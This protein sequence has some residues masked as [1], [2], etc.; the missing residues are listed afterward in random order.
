MRLAIF[1]ASRS[2]LSGDYGAPHGGDL[3]CRLWTSRIRLDDALDD[4]KRREQLSL[5][6]R[7]GSMGHRVSQLDDLF[8]GGSLLLRHMPSGVNT[9]SA[10]AIAP[11]LSPL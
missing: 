1:K 6:R 2:T 9:K 10:T 7:V 4:V 3:P 11:A 5:C 8:K